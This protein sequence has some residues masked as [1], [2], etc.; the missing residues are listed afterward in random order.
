MEQAIGHR[1]RRFRSAILAVA[2]A[3]LGSVLV[4]LA[5]GTPASA[6]APVVDPLLDP[7][8][9]AASVPTPDVSPVLGT[10]T[11]P[12]IYCGNGWYGPADGCKYAKAKL[13]TPA[14]ITATASLSTP[15]TGGEAQPAG[16]AT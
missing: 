8:L 4:Q 11:V 3:L 12:I 14:A 6:L 7:V 16:P 9:D 13:G 10:A 5:V 2:V 15:S 1:Q